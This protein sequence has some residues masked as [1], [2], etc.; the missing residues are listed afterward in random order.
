MESTGAIA[1]RFGLSPV[2]VW[3]AIQDGR[4]AA[5]EIA[6]GTKRA[7]LVNPEDAEKLWG[8]KTP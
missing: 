2:S 5:T 4:L 3:R 7:Y 8:Q 1:H 6:Y